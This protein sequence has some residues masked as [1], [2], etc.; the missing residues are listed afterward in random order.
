[1]TNPICSTDS[2]LLLHPLWDGVI[3]MNRLIDNGSDQ[4]LYVFPVTAAATS[5]RKKLQRISLY[6][7]GDILSWIFFSPLSLSLF[8]NIQIL[9]IS[10]VD[11][12]ILKVVGGL[13]QQ[14]E[15]YSLPYT[16][17]FG[18]KP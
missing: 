16:K 11:V 9:F 5:R 7:R 1:M 14:F 4:F 17:L 13:I 15:L 18:H 6:R 2:E 12:E 10:C 8:T 3:G